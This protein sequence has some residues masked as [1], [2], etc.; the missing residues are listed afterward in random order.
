MRAHDKVKV[1]DI[2]KAMKLSAIYKELSIITDIDEQVTTKFVESKDLPEKV[3]I[4]Q[5]IEGDI[6]AQEMS[7]IL[8]ARM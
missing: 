5:Y 7:N 8:N 4:G 2:Y 1:F 6:K 3:F